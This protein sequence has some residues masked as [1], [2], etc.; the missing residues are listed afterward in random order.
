MTRNDALSRID[1][2]ILCLESCVQDYLGRREFILAE[3]CVDA[4]LA[5]QPLRQVVF[6]SLDESRPLIHIAKQ[7]T[8]PLDA[9]GKPAS[10][11]IGKI[12]VR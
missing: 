12:D 6:N 1:Q 3:C 8:G 7:P 11:G 4:Q 5:L 2:A 10:G 9:Y